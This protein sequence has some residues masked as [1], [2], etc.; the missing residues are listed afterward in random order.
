MSQEKAIIGKAKEVKPLIINNEMTKDVEKRILIGK[1]NYGAPNFVMRLFTVKPG[2]Y[3]PKHSHRWEHEIFIVKGK[4][5]VYDGEKYNTVEA[6][7]F[8][9][10][11]GG[12]EHQLKNAGDEDLEFICVIPTSADEE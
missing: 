6:G 5:E 1:S 8:V 11:P 3:S 10:V 12:I 9:Y 4:A 2:G 7:S